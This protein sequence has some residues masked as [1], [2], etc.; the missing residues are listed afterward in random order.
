MADEDICG[1]Q[2]GKPSEGRG[3]PAIAVPRN[4]GVACDSVWNYARGWIV[5]YGVD[6][7]RMLGLWVGHEYRACTL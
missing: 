4:L 3:G 6:P 2:R 1:H 5:F 7:R